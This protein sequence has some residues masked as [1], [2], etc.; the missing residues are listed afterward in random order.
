VTVFALGLLLAELLM[1]DCPEIPSVEDPVALHSL[2]GCTLEDSC[3]EAD[4]KAH[5]SALLVLLGSA[6][7]FLEVDPFH[8]WDL[9]YPSSLG[10]TI[11]LA[12]FEEV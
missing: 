2:P 5:L 8:Y 6:R 4:S 7:F 10:Y 1:M 9:C 12:Q 3:S 11:A